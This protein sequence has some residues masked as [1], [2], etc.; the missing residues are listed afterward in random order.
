MKLVRSKCS[1]TLGAAL[2]NALIHDLKAL[3]KEDINLNHIMLDK[4]KLD[5]A[6]TKVCVVS[7]NVETSDIFALTCLEVDGKIHKDTL[8]CSQLTDFPRE[9]MLKK[10][11]ATENHQIFTKEDGKLPESYLTHGEIPLVNFM[12]LLKFCS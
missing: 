2:A 11:V 1:S 4:F 6:K 9:F 5:R 3:F 12:K 7:E 10:T 8:T